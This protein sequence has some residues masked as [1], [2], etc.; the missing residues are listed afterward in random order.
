L[1]GE[2]LYKEDWPRARA[3]LEAWWDGEVVDRTVVQVLAP[4]R[5][6]EPRFPGGDVERFYGWDG[7]GFARDPLHPEV[8]IGNFE[9]MCSMV[10][11][12]GEAFPN[13]RVNLGPGVAAAFLGASARF[14]PDSRTVWFETPMPWEKLGGLRLDP[15]NEWWRRARWIT[16]LAAEAGEGRFFVGITDLGGV[17]DIAA[18]LRGSQ[19]LVL[20]LFRAPDRVKALS[21]KILDAW[22]RYYDGLHVIIREKMAGTSAWMGIWSPRR[23][24][25]I[26]CDFSAMLS[27]GLFRDFT[28]PYL[29]EQCRRLDHTVYH[30]DGPGQIPHLDQLLSIS[31]LH[32]IQWVPGAGNPPGHSPKWLPLYRRIQKAGKLLVINAERT[33][34]RHLLSELS[35]K[36]LL[37]KTT[38]RSEEE[39]RG[40]LE[41]AE[42]WT[43]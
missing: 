14:R 30:M 13:L 25:P 21:R 40:L 10:Y 6:A 24:Y 38:C 22:H 31:E 32:G 35:P 17:T 4:R 2:M 41:R 26:Q 34:L 20:D 27:P 7:W 5:G 43:R 1:S 11:F 33:H 15:E 23:W 8:T 28:L 9:R 36:G 42:A 29:R 37:I 19:S 39:A 18:S 16:S 12:G 3:R